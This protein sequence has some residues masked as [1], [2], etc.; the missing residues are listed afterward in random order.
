MNSNCCPKTEETVSNFWLLEHFLFSLKCILL[1][2]PINSKRMGQI[3]LHDIS[4]G[5][6]SWKKIVT[7]FLLTS[8]SHV[9]N[10]CSKVPFRALVLVFSRKYPSFLKKQTKSLIL[11]LS[12]PK[13]HCPHSISLKRTHKLGKFYQVTY[14]EFLLFLVMSFLGKISNCTQILSLLSFLGHCAGGWEPPEAGHSLPPG[15]HCQR[16]NTPRPV[17]SLFSSR[18]FAL[19]YDVLN[20]CYSSCSFHSIWEWSLAQEETKQT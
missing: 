7:T 12:L 5:R 18:I 1:I 10:L 4:D 8:T 3:R 11:L 16:G 20:P 17:P 13:T 9:L 2:S 6:L 15:W 19:L 14:E